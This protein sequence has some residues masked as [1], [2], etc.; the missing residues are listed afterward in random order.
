M[1]FI[2]DGDWENVLLDRLYN[3]H[4]NIKLIIEVNP[5]NS[6]DTNGVCNFNVYWKNTKPPYP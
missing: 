1:I 3:Y 6:L 2:K 5:S 4:P